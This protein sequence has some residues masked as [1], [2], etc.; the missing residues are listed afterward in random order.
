MGSNYKSYK[1]KYY[2][3][4]I[5]D[6]DVDMKKFQKSEVSNMKWCYL[7]EVLSIIR[8]YNLE[9]REIIIKIDK[10]LHKYSLIS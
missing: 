10:I 5:N 8:P 2:L 7:E 4:Y 9:K 3:A 6:Y 1:H